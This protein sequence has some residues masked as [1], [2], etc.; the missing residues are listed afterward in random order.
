MLELDGVLLC[1]K[2]TFAFTDFEVVGW[3]GF[4]SRKSFM[5]IHLDSAVDTYLHER[6][7]ISFL[8]LKNPLNT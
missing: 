5:E 6:N 1:E 4:V 7:H 3:S 8:N 2:N